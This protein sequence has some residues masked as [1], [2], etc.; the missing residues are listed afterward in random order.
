[1]KRVLLFFSFILVLTACSDK[2]PAFEAP[3]LNNIGDYQVAITTHSPY[4]QL[5]FNQGVIMANSFNHAE[6]ERSFR[7][8]IRQDSTVAMGYWGIA[9]VLGPNY[10]SGGQNMGAIE[11]IRNAVGNAV[12]FSSNA[13]AWERAV[14]NAIQIKFPTDILT[15]NDDGYAASMKAAYAEFPENDFVATLYAESIMNLHAWDFYTKKGGEPRP[16]TAE[17]HAVLEHAIAINPKNPLANHLYIHAAEAGPDVEKALESAERLKF[18]VPSAGHLVHM[19][20]HIYINTGDYHAGSLANEQAVIADS[21]YIAECNS[22]GVYPQYY[23]PHNY[24]FLAATAAFEGRGA[25][26]IEAAYKTVSILD[27]KYFRETGYE[28]VLHYATIPL[29]VLVKFEQWEKILA[30]P[31]P[32]ADLAYPNAIWHYARGM[33]LANLNKPAEARIELDALNQLSESEDVERIIIWSI[34][35]ANQVCN[36]ASKVLEAELKT[37]GGDYSSAIPL[38]KQA[39]ELEDGLN[40]NEPPDWFFSVRHLL[41]DVLMNAK[42]YAAAEAIYREDLAAW[43]RNGFALNG[44]Y[45]SL[46]GQNKKAEAEGVRQQMEAAWMYADSD[47]HFSRI[48]KNKRKD[49]VLEIDENSPNTIV[50]LASALCLPK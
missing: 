16:W 11:E 9:Y 47:L 10:N 22:Q 25:K 2:Q 40:Y 49:L 50:Y 8:S 15:T 4:A 24:H 1:M 37:V 39:I 26:S 44:L 27:K 35:P 5:F 28:T 42:D 43:P 3:V 21:I 45:E 46:N 14:I 33:A 6:A 23:Y 20:S 29:H 32:D 12:R 17:L 48:D 7:E 19:P 38:L 31:Q 18:L 13:S 30:S 41:G 36:I 34:N